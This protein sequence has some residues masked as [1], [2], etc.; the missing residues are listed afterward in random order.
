[1]ESGLSRMPTK[2]LKKKFR[3]WMFLVFIVPLFALASWWFK[4]TKYYHSETQYSAGVGHR[5]IYLRGS[6]YWLQYYSAR[7]YDKHFVKITL[8]RAV[9]ESPIFEFHPYGIFEEEQHWKWY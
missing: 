7:K 4:D 9:T 1:M 5:E 8:I 2:V 6:I 3:L